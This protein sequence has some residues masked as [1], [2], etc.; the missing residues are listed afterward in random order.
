MFVVGYFLV[1]FPK[2]GW[3]CIC[4]LHSINSVYDIMHCY[5]DIHKKFV[6]LA[7][8]FEELV[9]ITGDKW[10]V[11]LIDSDSVSVTNQSMCDGLRAKLYLLKMTR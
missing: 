3:L 8:L 10:L 9:R 2:P 11:S 1:F 6:I 5:L 4:S 7:W